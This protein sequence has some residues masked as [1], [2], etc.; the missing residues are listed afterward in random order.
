M[1]YLVVSDNHGDK[2]VVDSIKKYWDNKVDYFFHCGDSELA[3]SDKLWEVFHVVRGNCDYEPKYETTQV[4]NTGADI[5]FLTHGHL[6]QVNMTL[7]RLSEAGKSVNAS[8]VLYGHTHKLLCE[9]HEG[10][11]Y[12]NPG[13]ISQPRGKYKDL[14]TY[15]VIEHTEKGLSV[16]Y[17]NEYHLLQKELTFF[18]SV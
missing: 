13:S 14:K 12:L 10:V 11:L 8:I 16:N 17:Y 2:H 15:A 7:E 4:V 3:P 9:M 1:K 5:V 6:Y 18:F